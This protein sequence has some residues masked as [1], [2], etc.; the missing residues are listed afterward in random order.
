[1][2]HKILALKEDCGWLHTWMD[3]VSGQ[4]LLLL[5]AAADAADT[6]ME[7]LRLMDNEGQ[8]TPGQV[9]EING[10]SKHCLDVLQSEPG[11]YVKHRGQ[12]KRIRVSAADR[13]AV[14]QAFKP[15]VHLCHEACEAEFPH[16]HLFSSMGVLDLR[17]DARR[18]DERYSCLRRLAAALQ[19]MSKGLSLSLKLFA[20]WPWL[21]EKYETK[22]LAPLLRAHA[23][24]TTSSSG[25]EQAFSKAQRSQG[26]KHFGPK[27]AESERRAMVS[28]TYTDSSATP[29]A[30]VVDKARE[31]YASKVSRHLGQHKGKR[32]DKG[33]KR[34]PRT[35]LA[36]KLVEKTWINRRRASVKAAA[37]QSSELATSRETARKKKIEAHR[38]GYYHGVDAAEGLSLEQE[39][40]KRAREDSKADRSMRLKRQKRQCQL[41]STTKKCDWRWQS[42]GPAK[43]WFASGLPPITC[44]PG[45]PREAGPVW[46]CERA[47]PVK[48]LGSPREAGPAWRAVANK[49]V[50]MYLTFVTEGKNDSQLQLQVSQWQAATGLQPEI[51]KKTILVHLDTALLGESSGPNCQPELRGKRW[52]PDSDLVE[53]LAACPCIGLGAQAVD[54]V[55]CSL[56]AEGTVVAVVDPLGAGPKLFKEAS[57]LSVWLMF[58]EKS[59]CDRKQIVRAGAYSQQMVCNLY[60]EKPLSLSTPEVERK[61]YPGYSHGDVIGYISCLGASKL[62]R[63]PRKDKL[64]VLG[65]R[66]VSLAKP[67][68][69]ASERGTSE[70][71]GSAG[72]GELESV[73]S[74]SMLP[75]E[76]YMEMKL[77]MMLTEFI[78]EEQQRDGSTFYIPE[79]KI[80]KTDE[81]PEAVPKAKAKAKGKT[82]KKRGKNAEATEK[83]NEANPE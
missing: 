22:N 78:F 10:Y 36:G 73:F 66:H 77:E 13:R 4:R 62:W 19:L 51:G 44:G 25:V 1:V 3:A 64:D 2:L 81:Q 20:Q 38:D 14:L 67:A 21:S 74:C 57:K 58:N 43:A 60:T 50:R 71:D 45:S 82:T 27:A 26:A 46:L 72:A 80:A 61:I 47:D 29:L 15:W 70:P 48:S 12:Q 35:K 37:A 53:K 5:A 39:A 59:V 23:C 52:K 41:L 65:A 9:F 33:V 17:S 83:D 79:M 28:L 32:F 49:S 54:K 16:F 56:P 63:A 11:L 7:F 34:G 31:L 8:G 55:R 18:T 40:M 6:V 69:D 24:W 76:Y 75:Q 42:L 30:S 68:D